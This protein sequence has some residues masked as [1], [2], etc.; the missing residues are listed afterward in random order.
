MESSSS[1]CGGAGSKYEEQ[2][3]QS[4]HCNGYHNQKGHSTMMFFVVGR[5]AGK[6][7]DFSEN[8]CKKRNQNSPNHG[9]PRLFP[10]AIPFLSIRCCLE[11]LVE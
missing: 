10:S 1:L 8:G 5:I 11:P 2:N 4:F 6:P 7:L 9:K 3:A